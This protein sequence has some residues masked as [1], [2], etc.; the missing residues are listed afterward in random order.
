MNDFKSI[1]CPTDFSVYSEYAMRYAQAFA[2]QSGGKIHC[3][4]VVDSRAVEGGG[5][6]G[7]YIT[8]AD[9]DATLAAVKEHAEAKMEHVVRKA[10]YSTADV[11]GHVL[12]G[13]PADDIAKLAG[14]LKA[15][16]VVVSTHGRTG[17]DRLIL[18]STCD[19][20]LRTSPAPV[21]A[22]KHPEHE[23]VESDKTIHLKKVLVPCDFSAFSRE[24]V[25]YAADLCRKF[26]AS[27]TLAHIVDTWLDYPEFTPTIAVN[28]TPNL[29]RA[30]KESLDTLAKEQKDVKVDVNVTVGV[31]HRILTDMI[32]ADDVDLVVMTTHG[33]SA[34]AH[35]LLGSVTEKVVRHSSC[36][37]LVI[38]PRHTSN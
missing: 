37:V 31:P 28:N 22:I 29:T 4:H 25:P 16:L 18:G 38:H 30:A 24:A 34:L 26:G 7:I 17:L 5:V 20:I 1:L 11:E 36:P 19:K 10:K 8:K 27:L 35:L 33:R 13:I 9:V 6:E 21:L 12:V 32:K 23:F 14:D 3:V 2:K 15:D